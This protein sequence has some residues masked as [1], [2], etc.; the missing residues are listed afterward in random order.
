MH[1]IRE[2]SSHYSVGSAFDG[3]SL[4]QQRESYF[5][6]QPSNRDNGYHSI[7]IDSECVMKHVRVAYLGINESILS[8]LAII[9]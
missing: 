9:P 8:V 5:W 7:R 2:D 6:S 3:H 4:V 1:V